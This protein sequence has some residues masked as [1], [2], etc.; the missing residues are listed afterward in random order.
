MQRR[1]LLFIGIAALVMGSIFS[2]V[3][4][5]SLQKRMTPAANGVYVLVAAHNLMPGEKLEERDLKMARYPGDFLPPDVLRTQAGAIGRWTGVPM[6]Q[7]DFV[8]S[9]KLTDDG[10]LPSL[11][12]VGMRAAPVS[13]NDVVSVAGFAKPGTLVD[14]L[15]TGYEPESHKLQTSTV[16]Q[17]IRV[18][19]AGTQLEHAA[20]RD[21]REAHVVTLLVSPEDAEKLTLA[22]QEG[23]IQLIIRN[24]RD[25]SQEKRP[26]VRDLYDLGRKKPV[27]AKYV[28]VTNPPKDYEIELLRGPQQ[29]KSFKFKQ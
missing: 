4:Y 3:V 27:R 11:I 16:L 29:Q 26:P 17:S 1:R 9:S 15:L 21:A 28:P 22:T 13:V 14:V 20:A 7:G 23:H 2:S 5:Q 6:V 8:T 12:P 25:A 24:P 19:A 18:L 10:G